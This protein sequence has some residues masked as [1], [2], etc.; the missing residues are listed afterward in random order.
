MRGNLDTPSCMRVLAPSSL[1]SNKEGKAK[2]AKIQAALLG[3]SH[4]GSAEAAALELSQL[5]AVPHRD[6]GGMGDAT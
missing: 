2:C 5:Y 3:F 1:T 6:L 4:L